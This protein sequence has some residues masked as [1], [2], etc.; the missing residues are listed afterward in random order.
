VHNKDEADVVCCAHIVDN[1]NDNTDQEVNFINDANDNAAENNERITAR[2]ATIHRNP[3]PI[4]DVELSIYHTAQRVLLNSTTNVYVFNYEQDR[5]DLT[6]HTYDRPVPESVIDYSDAL[7]FK[8]KS[9][10]IHDVT[11][12]M[13]ILSSRTDNVAMTYIK[14]KLNDVGMKG[15]SL[16]T[17]KILRKETTRTIE[18][19]GYN[20]ICFHTM[21]ME[22]GIDSLMDTFPPEST[23][24]HH[25]VA[26]VVI[27]QD[28]R[29][30][31][32]WVNKMTCKLIDTGITSIQQLESKLD[33]N[34]L[35]DHLDGLG[36]PTLHAITIMGFTH[37]LGTANFCQ[38]RS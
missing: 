31:N 13:Y 1:N 30:P 36:M 22:I 35:N 7:R 23:L 27:N 10:G 37:I 29:K 6:S 16:N 2:R 9:A 18:H 33:S 28:R 25:V 38:G 20:S 17:V 11:R 3:N 5:P 21:E 26:A 4:K 19:N 34:S 12:L 14:R 15:L 8:L 24:L 32:R